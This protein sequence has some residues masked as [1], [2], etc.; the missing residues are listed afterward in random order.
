MLSLIH[1]EKKVLHSLKSGRYIGGQE[2]EDFENN[3]SKAC[4]AKYCITTEMDWMLF[5]LD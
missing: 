3:Y 5:F 2:V 4:N 1:F